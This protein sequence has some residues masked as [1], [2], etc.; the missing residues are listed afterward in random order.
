MPILKAMKSLAGPPLMRLARF[1]VAF[2]EGALLSVQPSGVRN[3]GTFANLWRVDPRLWCH[4]LV[5]DGR[6]GTVGEQAASTEP[7]RTI[8][9]VRLMIILLVKFITSGYLLFYFASFLLPYNAGPHQRWHA[10][11]RSAVGFEQRRAVGL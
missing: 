11:P 4:M 1:L 3:S 2:T 7:I 8:I 6:R 9:A 10:S 5:G